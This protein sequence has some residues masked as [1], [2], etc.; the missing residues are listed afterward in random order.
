MITLGSEFAVLMLIGGNW[1]SVQKIRDQLDSLQ[2]TSDLS[3]TSRDSEQKEKRDLVPYLIDVV[4]L[5]HEGIVMGLSGFFSDRG[6]E[7]A[8]LSTRRYNAPHTGAAMVSVQ[9]TVSLPPNIQVA[10]LR[11]EFL[12]YCDAENL[13]AIMEPADR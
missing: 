1:H 4:S 2:S 6:I 13:D 11:D 5:D 8:E 10:H 7:I 9:R 3:I 12:D